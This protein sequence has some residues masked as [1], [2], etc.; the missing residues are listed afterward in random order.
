M[1]TIDGDGSRPN[2]V[3]KAR[4]P[5]TFPFVTSTNPEETTPISRACAV[6][7]G[8]VLPATVPGPGII[9]GGDGTH[10]FVTVDAPVGVELE[11]GAVGAMTG[12]LRR[13]PVGNDRPW[14]PVR[15][16]V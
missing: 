6:Y 16:A 13:S 15:A 7:E 3:L 5:A 8:T 2:T 12:A 1:P 9:T 14:D 10:R 11:P 4:F